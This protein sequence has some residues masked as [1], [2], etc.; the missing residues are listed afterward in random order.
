M[1]VPAAQLLCN[2]MLVRNVKDELTHVALFI[3][4][5][6]TMHRLVESLVGWEGPCRGWLVLD[7]HTLQEFLSVLFILHTPVCT[8]SGG[9]VAHSEFCVHCASSLLGLCITQLFVWQV[10]K[11]QM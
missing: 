10:G 6:P 7:G 2:A 9:P 5:T 3:L 11:I 8:F 4:G 1:Y